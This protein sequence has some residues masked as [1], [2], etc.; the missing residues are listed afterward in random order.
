MKPPV[1][2]LPNLQ[3]LFKLEWDGSEEYEMSVVLMQN[4]RHITYHSKMFQGTQKNY[5]TNDKNLLLCIKQLNI[6][7]N[8]F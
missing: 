4:G 2:V 3:R 5:P 8:T 1:L 6:S 7:M